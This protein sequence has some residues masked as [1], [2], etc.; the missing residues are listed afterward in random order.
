MGEQL[1]GHDETD[2]FAFDMKRHISALTHADPQARPRT[3]SSS[4]W[5]TAAHTRAPSSAAPGLSLRGCRGS[6]KN[7]GMS[8]RRPP[9]EKVTQTTNIGMTKATAKRVSHQPYLMDGGLP[10]PNSPRRGMVLSYPNQSNRWYS[11]KRRT[12]AG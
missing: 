10:H 5:R 12:V 7:E 11:S 1:G 3:A 8:P 4:P 2:S 6:Y 9:I